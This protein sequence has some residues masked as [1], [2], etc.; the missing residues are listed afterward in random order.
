MGLEFQSWI[1]DR[2]RESRYVSVLEWGGGGFGVDV[3][4]PWSGI[5]GAAAGLAVGST[6]KYQQVRT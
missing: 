5:F 4:A 6:W 3:C 1:A 2:K